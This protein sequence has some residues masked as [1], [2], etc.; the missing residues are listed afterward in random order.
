MLYIY[1]YIYIHV[2]IYII[3]IIILITIHIVVII[4]TMYYTVL[5]LSLSLLAS[6]CA[7]VPHSRLL[8]RGARTFRYERCWRKT[9]ETLPLEI[10]SSTKPDP[11]VVHA[12]AGKLRPVIVLSEPT[13]LDERTHAR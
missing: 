7:R 10:S 11:S 12:Y 8:R 5:L 1:I 2:Y 6:P 13:H 9:V 3:V 4:I